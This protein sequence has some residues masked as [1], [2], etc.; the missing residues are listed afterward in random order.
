MIMAVSIVD[1]LLVCLSGDVGLIIRRANVIASL[2]L[3]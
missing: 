1:P 2:N 3:H